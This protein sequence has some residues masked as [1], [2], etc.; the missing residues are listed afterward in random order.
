[1]KR[2]FNESENVVTQAIDGIL[3]LSGEHG[4]K[5]A[6]AF[7]AS[8]FVT[9]NK[10]DKSKVAIISGGGAGHEP[11]HIGFIG[12]GMLTAAVSGEVFASPSVE[13]VL[14]CILHVTGD[15]GCLLIVKNYT[16]DRLN[17]GLAAERAKKA[18][19]KVEMVVVSDDIAIPNAPQPRGIAGTLFVHKIAGHLAEQGS[20]LEAVKAGAIEAAKNSFSLG[21]A[22]STCSLP[23]TEVNIIGDTAELGLGIH[24]EPGLDKVSFKGGKEAVTMVLSKLFAKTDSDERYAILI[25][26]LGSITPLEMSIIT[27]EVLQS[28]YKD[29]IELVIGPA[30]LM[31]SLNMYGF[32]F[33]IIKL[34]KENR[35]MLK[36]EVAPIAWPKAMEPK[37]PVTFDISYQKLRKEFLPSRNPRT[38]HFIQTI[39]LNL[40][41]A[42]AYLNELDK[43]IGDGDT[44]ATFAAGA[45]GIMKLLDNHSLPLDNTSDLLTNMGELLAS[46]MGGSSG[47]LLSIMFT[48]AGAMMSEGMDFPDALENGVNMMMKYGG[49]RKGSRTMV[50]VLL[51][52]IEKLKQGSLEEAAIAARKAA[53]DTAKMDKASSGRSSYLRA[54]S[55][56]GVIDPGSEAVAIVFECITTK[57]LETV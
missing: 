56:L 42:E 48:N 52:A 30:S 25:N 41:D 18:G 53:N 29:Q 35:A 37:D 10:I 4:V 54:E 38:E 15:A 46:Y 39:C 50:D 57:N 21:L 20:C 1:M 19:K 43:K 23:G 3:R 32:S 51:P 24:G 17:F 28:R 12:K 14:S 8:K 9:R 49:A 45:R 31:T 33:S 44:G 2:Y 13:A 7:P 16:G 27:D 36:S 34:T 11:A 6:D 40:L 22:V 5:R 55:L 47:V 26:N